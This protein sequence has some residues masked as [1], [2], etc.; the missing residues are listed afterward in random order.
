MKF[1]FFF[2]IL[3]LQEQIFDTN[4]EICISEI[5]L[6]EL[7][8]IKTSKDKDESIKYS[9][10]RLIRLLFNN[11]DKYNVIKFDKDDFL[12]FTQHFRIDFYNSSPDLKIISCAILFSISSPC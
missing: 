1:F 3:I 2:S 11:K 10:R 9:A 5:T 7:E 4:E 6:C 12:D 8:K